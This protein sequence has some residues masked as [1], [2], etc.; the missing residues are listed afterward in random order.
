M[1]DVV[2]LLVLMVLAIV[3]IKRHCIDVRVIGVIGSVCMVYGLYKLIGLAQV[4]V[5]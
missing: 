1:I 4:P 3:D 5:K 2:V